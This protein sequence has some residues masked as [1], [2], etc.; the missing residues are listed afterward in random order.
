MV[1]NKMKLYEIAREYEFLQHAASEI[2]FSEDDGSLNAAKD[3]LSEIS[4]EFH[5]K[6]VSVSAV[7]KN[8]EADDKIIRE[9]I[10][11]LLSRSSR[12]EKNIEWLRNYLLQNMNKVE[13]KTIQSPLFDISVIQNP[14]SVSITDV[15]AIPE[16]YLKK[17][18][19]FSINKTEIKKMLSLG[20]DVPGAELVKK[21]RLSIK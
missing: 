11:K 13:I 21:E 16:E 18:E 7:I 14:P 17:S 10:T 3:H 9:T 8:L 5:N 1:I 12:I 15:K 20:V 19:I 4:D 6:A 2:E